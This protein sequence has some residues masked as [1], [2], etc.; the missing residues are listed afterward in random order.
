M[1]EEEKDDEA[2]AGL[3]EKGGEYSKT[4]AK[5]ASTSEFSK[6]Y[7]LQIW[8]PTPSDETLAEVVELWQSDAREQGL[9]PAKTADTKVSGEGGLTFVEVTGRVKKAADK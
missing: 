4:K 7:R 5:S 9:V 6:T 2:Q 1:A 8:P 3:V